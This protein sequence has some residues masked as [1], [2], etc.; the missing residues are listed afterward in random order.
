VP[1]LQRLVDKTSDDTLFYITTPSYDYLWND[2]DILGGHFRRYNRKL[3]MKMGLD[4]GLEPL[5]FS[6]FFSYLTVPYLLFR[7]LPFRFGKKTSEEDVI[8]SELNAHKYS[9]LMSRIFAPF[10][11]ME[12]N[13]IKRNGG[14]PFGTSSVIIFKKK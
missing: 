14:I 5:F 1:F 10:H 3:L 4:A 11:Y 8:K 7:V 12:K 2:M 6:Y 13:M 9:R